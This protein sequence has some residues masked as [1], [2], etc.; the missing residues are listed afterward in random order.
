MPEFIAV[1]GKLPG[2]ENGFGFFLNK[3]LV[4][5]VY[6]VWAVTEQGT[7]WEGSR[8]HPEA[9][10]G[11]KV[12]DMENNEH[13]LVSEPST[14]LTDVEIRLVSSKVAAERGRFGFDP[15]HPPKS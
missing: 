5:A 3:A 9:K 10:L 8:T 11:F 4:K 7:R 2:H 1:I 15:S 13:I 6:P 14:L 12:I